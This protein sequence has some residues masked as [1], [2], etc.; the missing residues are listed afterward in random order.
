[1]KNA[2]TRLDGLY[3]AGMKLTTIK[4]SKQ[5]LHNKAIRTTGIDDTENR[6]EIHRS[7]AKTIK[8]RLLA[9]AWRILELIRN[10]ASYSGS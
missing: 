9:T 8:N 6:S 2:A 7:I 1:M 3:M 5:I 10:G 4:L